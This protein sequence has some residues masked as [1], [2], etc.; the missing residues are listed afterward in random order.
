MNLPDFIIIGAMKAATTSL[1]YYLNLHPQIS[2]SREKELN[3][4]V[5][6]QNWKKG[7]DWYKSNF[8]NEKPLRGEASPNYTNFPFFKGV[9][10]RMHSVVPDIKL[11][12]LVRDPVERILSQYVHKMADGWEGRSLEKGLS[13]LN[14]NR[15]VARSLYFMQIDQYLKFFPR[16]NILVVNSD[17]LINNNRLAMKSIFEFLNVDGSFYDAKFLTT[18]HKSN[19]KRRKSPTGQILRKRSIIKN[20][21]KLPYSFRSHVDWLVFLPFS[22]KIKKPVLSESLKQRI[23]EYLQEDIAQLRKF[24]GQK[25]SNWCL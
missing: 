21:D 9:P 8:N 4:F 18:L 12:Y 20:I 7:I 24:T 16:E 6:K 2:M 14:T 19:R 23:I 25:F 22:Q 1:H 5:K 3:F 15:Y 11:I 13:N 10:E 17:D